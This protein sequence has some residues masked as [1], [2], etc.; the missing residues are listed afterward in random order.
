METEVT[1]EVTTEVMRV[2]A[3]P[4]QGKNPKK[5]AAGRAAAAARKAKE[6]KLREELRAA[7]EAHLNNLPTPVPAPTPAP[8]PTPTPAPARENTDWTPW[9]VGAGLV[10][11]AIILY[12][13]RTKPAPAQQAKVTPAPAQQLKA[14]AD[15]FYMQ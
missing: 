7:K 6:E 5:V 11:S 12:N 14:D 8:A 3:E 1:P 2:T 4:E 10:G 13:Q 9:V 15:P